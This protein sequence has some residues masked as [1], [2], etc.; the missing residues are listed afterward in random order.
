MSGWV[1]NRLKDLI[2]RLPGLAR[3]HQ[4]QQELDRRAAALAQGEADLLR[5]AL[6]FRSLLPQAMTRGRDSVDRTPWTQPFLREGNVRRFAEI[7]RSVWAF[8]AD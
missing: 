1:R 5:K 2:M 3:I 7:S 4:K 8:A 6:R